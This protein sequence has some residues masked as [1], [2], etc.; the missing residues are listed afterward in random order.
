M[1]KKVAV[2]SICVVFIL[3][4]SAVSFASM[5]GLFE[6]YPIV[7]VI[8]DGQEIKGDV[9]AINFKGRTMVPVRF[10]SEALGADITWDA[11]NET[12]IISTV[13]EPSSQ[14]PTGTK[15]PLTVSEKGVTVTLVSVNATSAGTT[16]EM[17]ITNNTN[18]DVD[19][20]ASLTQIVAGSTQFDGPSDYDM[21][22]IDILRPGVTKK[23]EL[24]FP[25]LPMGTKQI[26]IYSKVWIGKA[27]DTVEANFTVS[28]N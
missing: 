26:N 21:T 28:V 11:E 8:V 23:G 24:K 3:V 9:P 7:K 19:F 27:L 5:H 17:E 16:L 2:V 14:K 6:G 22:F 25:P 13:A 1:C 10:V 18:Q 4:L 12:V 20:P 15:P